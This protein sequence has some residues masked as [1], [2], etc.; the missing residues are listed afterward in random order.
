MKKQLYTTL[1]RP[2]VTY[3]VETWKL[4]NND[5]RKLMIFERKILRK[6]VGPTKNRETGEWRIRKNNEMESLFK[7]ENIVNAI[8]NR[9]LQ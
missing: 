5:E 7:K 1:I 3:G 9:R 4:R 8:R 2:V 6:I